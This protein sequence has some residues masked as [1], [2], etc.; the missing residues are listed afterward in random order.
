MPF[1][2]W[3]PTYIFIIIGLAISG[4][5]SSYVKS[6]YHKFSDVKSSKGYTATQVSRMIL[7]SADLQHVRL[8]GIRGDLTD[9]YDSKNDVL[10]LSETTRKSTSVAAIGVAAHEAGH[11]IQDKVNYGP[12]RLR[13]AL[14]PV[15]N[16][17]QGVSFPLIFAGVIFG[18]NQTL[19]DLGIL[20]FSLTLVFQLVTLPVEFNASNRAVLILKEQQI[21]TSQELSQAE[22]VLKAAALTYVAAAL[23]SFLNVLRLVI[24]FGGRRRD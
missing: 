19:I 17:G 13:A 24:L 12:L 3:D 18:Y 22:K 6:T 14:V 21:L 11:A 8:E 23:A 7:D 1:F 2:I 10:R 15:T 5:A 9:H 4:I 20:F 16:F